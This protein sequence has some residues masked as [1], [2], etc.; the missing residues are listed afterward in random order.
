MTG[1]PC[2][3]C[4]EKELEQCGTEISREMAYIKYRCDNCGAKVEKRYA[5]SEW[6]VIEDDYKDEKYATTL[7]E[8]A[9]QYGNNL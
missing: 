8:L 1:T 4:T 5:L 2:P 7:T 3:K 9:E 6:T